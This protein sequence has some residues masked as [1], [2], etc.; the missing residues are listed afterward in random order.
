[1][2]QRAQHESQIR[3][4]SDSLE[5]RNEQLSQLEGAL[6]ELQVE[7]EAIEAEKEKLETAKHKHAAAQEN[8]ARD[9]EQ[10]AA[11]QPRLSA[12]EQELAGAQRLH[13]EEAAA[14]AER[15]RKTSQDY[16]GR[17][18][19][20]EDD[21]DLFRK[22]YDDASTHAQ[23]LARENAELEEGRQRAEERAQTGV[24]MVKATFTAHVA[25]LSA[26][27]ERL[28]GLVKVLTDKDERTNDEVRAR[29]AREPELREENAELRRENMEMRRKVEKMLIIGTATNWAEDDGRDGDYVPDPEDGSS[30]SSGSSSSDSD[31]DSDWRASPLSVREAGSFSPSSIGENYHV[32][33][34][35]S[36]E[37]MC[38]QTFASA[39]VRHFT[40]LL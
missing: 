38:N 2:K 19:T 24:A 16:E 15:L 5:E 25:A 36:G 1:M 32:C 6:V 39:Q 22:L 4:L 33:Q 23:R 29:A 12:L 30:P 10:L 9:K 7:V 21:R 20:I 35:V 13:E 3:E 8:D 11:L 40:N 18:K 14:L 28:T 37:D 27:V 34:H 26:E 31:S 17:V